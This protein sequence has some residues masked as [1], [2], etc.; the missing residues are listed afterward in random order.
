MYVRLITGSRLLT[1]VKFKAL[2]GVQKTHTTS[3]LGVQLS[4]P[5]IR[6]IGG[7]KDGQFI[8]DGII[9][10]N[11]KVALQFGEV[12]PVKYNVQVSYN[13]ALLE[14]G[15]ASAPFMLEPGD[16]GM[17]TLYYRADRSINVYELPW[18]IRLYIVE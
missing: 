9:K 10:P 7:E 14:S 18:I 3:Q 5:Q 2:E 15:L 4:R 17:L 6:I 11:Q 12:R 16:D 8:E 1:Y 13:P